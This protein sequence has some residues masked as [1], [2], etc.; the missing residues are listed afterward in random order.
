MKYTIIYTTDYNITQN[1]E[2]VTARDYTEAYL[3]ITYTK[4]I[5]TIILDVISEDL[6]A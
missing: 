6:R 5:G 2:T 1:A 4:P 3:I